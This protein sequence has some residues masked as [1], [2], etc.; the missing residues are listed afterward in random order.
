[1]IGGYLDNEID[2]VVGVDGV[3]ETVIYMTAVGGIG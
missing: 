1:M 3:Q 2:Q